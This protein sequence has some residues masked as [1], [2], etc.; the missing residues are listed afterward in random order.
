MQNAFHGAG[1]TEVAGEGR[2]VPV[3]K[4]ELLELISVATAQSAV[5]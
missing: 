3:G 4:A 2:V 1:L 5:G